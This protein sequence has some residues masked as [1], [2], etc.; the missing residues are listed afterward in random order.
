[1]STLFTDFPLQNSNK[2]KKS[3][4]FMIYQVATPC[5]CYPPQL[6]LNPEPR[7][8][9]WQLHSD[10]NGSSRQWTNCVSSKPPDTPS[11]SRVYTVTNTHLRFTL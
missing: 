8:P 4:L 1:V 6:S 5:R 9:F 11:R 3:I 7:Q 10:C 2:T